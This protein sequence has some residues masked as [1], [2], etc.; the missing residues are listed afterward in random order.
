M[1]LRTLFPLLVVALLVTTVGAAGA[2]TR[3]PR[4]ARDAARSRKAQ[5]ASQLNALKASERQ[6]LAASRALDDQVL[7]QAA[8][9]D[10]ARRAVSA[11]Q[12][13]LAEATRDLAETRQAKDRLSKLFVAR[14]V[15]QYISPRPS[16]AEVDTTGDL[17]AAARRKALLEAVAAGDAD[18]QDELRAAE[19]DYRIELAAATEARARAQSRRAETESQLATLE[20]N[21][22]AQRR[23]RAAVTARQREVLSEID[24]QSRSESALTRII[25]ERSRGGGGGTTARSGGCIWPARGRVTSEY[26][27]RWGRLHAGID[28]AAPKGTPIWAAKSGT[29]I[30]AGQQSGYGNVVIVDHGGGFTTLYGHQSRIGTREGASVGQGDTIGYVGNTGHSTGPHVHF[31]TRYGGTARNPR[32]CLS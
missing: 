10:A 5:L 23:L 21:Q 13:E 14:A 26:G 2:A 16:E 24:A 29:V 22:R 3:D 31:E 15:E 20:R 30:F 8:R 11:A 28:I 19:E 18:L 9:V 25:N 12:A 27:R 17:A 32:G 4:A 7:A 6:L 1:R